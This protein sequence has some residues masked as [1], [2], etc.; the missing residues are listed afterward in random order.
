MRPDDRSPAFAAAVLAHWWGED[1]PREP[2]TEPGSG[3]GSG[4]V[5]GIRVVVRDLPAHRRFQVLR[6]TGAGGLLTTTPE[7]AAHL[8]LAPG[9]QLHEAAVARVVEDAAAVGVHLNGADHVFH[10]SQPERA[11]VRAEGSADGVRLLSPEDGDDVAAFAA[12]GRAAPPDDAEEAYVELEHWRVVG[13]FDGDR[14]VA[15]ASAYPWA[16]SVLA[17]IGVLTLPEVRGRGHG[18]ACVRRLSGAVL[19]AGH[20]PLYRCQLDN[21]ASV[22]L[23]R[24]AG[25]T[26]FGTW[27]VVVGD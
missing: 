18:R 1:A 20:E 21:A 2:G 10:L 24:S 9:E 27:E 25:F 14:L 15:A 3:S 16:G 5:G 7:L 11:A 6:T 4:S 13:A 12:F 17:D 19:A 8:R 22:G 23:A 26:A